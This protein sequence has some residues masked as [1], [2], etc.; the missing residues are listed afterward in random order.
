MLV[1]APTNDQ[2]ATPA[3]M[4]TR[5]ARVPNLHYASIPNV[6]HSTTDPRTA[7]LFEMWV[8]H[9]EVDRPLN[10]VET[11]TLEAADGE[12]VARATITEAA[13]IDEVLFWYLPLDDE[14]YLG[15][16][17]W[18]TTPD[19]YFPSAAWQSVPMT[20]AGGGWEARLPEPASRLVAGWVDAADSVGG[21]PRYAAGFIELLP[22]FPDAEA[23]L[24]AQITA[25]CHART[26]N[27][28]RRFLE[29][30]TDGCMQAWARCLVGEALGF[31]DAATEA[32]CE[33][34]R[35]GCL[36]D[37]CRAELDP[38][39]ASGFTDCA[40]FRAA[41]LDPCEQALFSAALDASS[42]DLDYVADSCGLGSG[43]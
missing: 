36:N 18:W 25:D 11:T 13:P 21:R 22:L 33:D 32:A 12:V 1:I 28:C 39:A 4:E 30:C 20:R 29:R 3:L 31:C 38:C 8:E 2:N 6:G 9:V 10:T 7:E 15:A 26:G 27:A 37:A 14:T 19:D 42:T 34:A 16:E 35:T 23:S 43:G 24:C 41:C 5:M 17:F 40:D